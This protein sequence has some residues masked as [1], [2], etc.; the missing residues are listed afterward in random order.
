M[1][2]PNRDDEPVTAA[3]AALVTEREEE[4]QRLAA[5]LD[6]F[7]EAMKERLFQKVDEGYTGWDELEDGWIPE[8]RLLAEAEYVLTNRYALDGDYRRRKLVDA[9]NFA[10]FAW[11]LITP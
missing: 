10:M 2:V 6:A 5:T 8:E 11:A 7:A 3:L 9:A 4:K 1:T